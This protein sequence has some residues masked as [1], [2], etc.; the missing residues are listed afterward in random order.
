LW[1]GIGLAILAL[2]A[3]LALVRL[4]PSDAGAVPPSTR[5]SRRD[6]TALVRATG[7]VK[8]KVGAE[9]RVGS[10]VSGIVKRL[11]VRIGDRVTAG[12]LLAELDPTEWEARR[13]QA[14]AL[15]ESARTTMRYADVEA[16]RKRSLSDEGLISRAERDVSDQAAAVA[17][18]RVAEAE[19]N[20]R[21]LEIQRDYTRI[22]APISGLVA[23]VTTQE[24]E[25]VSAGLVAPTFVT[26]IDVD[27]LEVRAYVDE[28]DIGRIRRNQH[29]TFTVDTYPGTEFEGRVSAIY[30]SAEIQDNVV[31]YL[32]IVEIADRQRMAIRPEMTTTVG[33]ALDT[34]RGVLTVPRAA[35]STEG[36]RKYV[37]VLAASG[38]ERR[39][40]TT[41]WKD[42][43]HVEIVGGLNEGE[44]ILADP[45]SRAETPG[46]MAAAGGER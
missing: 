39:Q 2:S 14:A 37:Y 46:R 40:V 18:A 31:N 13:D 26:I 29:C 3:G 36:G 28:T 32:V 42:E 8:P 5:V 15:L 1:S 20:L 44:R 9:V 7:I 21:A 19:A 12:Q 23:T 30:P 6:M 10:R 41:G 25:T 33:I 27:R 24:G 11:H 22:T 34:R 16:G 35:V 38:T 17:R 4:R 45:P 43:Q